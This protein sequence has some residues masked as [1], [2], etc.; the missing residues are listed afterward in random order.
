M[1]DLE[2]LKR[3]YVTKTYVT[4]TWSELLLE[5]ELLLEEESRRQFLEKLSYTSQKNLLRLYNLKRKNSLSNTQLKAEISKSAITQAVLFGSNLNG[6]DGLYQERGFWTRQVAKFIKKSQSWLDLSKIRLTALF[7]QIRSRVFPEIEVNKLAQLKK[8][9]EPASLPLVSKISQPQSP[10]VHWKVLSAGFTVFMIAYLVGPSLY[11]QSLSLYSSLQKQVY[12][13]TDDY[14]QWSAVFVHSSQND[15]NQDPDVDGLTNQ[16][17]FWLKTDPM[18]ADQNENNI[19]DGADVLN[20]THPHNGASADSVNLSKNLISYRLQKIAL[21][22]EKQVDKQEV[23][24]VNSFRPEVNTEFKGSLSIPTL[25]YENVPIAWNVTGEEDDFYDVLL[26]EIIHSKDSALPGYPGKM[27]L[28][29]FNS[30][31]ETGVD[32]IINFN[33]IYKLEPRDEILVQAEALDGSTWQWKYLVVSRNLFVPSDVSQF[34]E[35]E[36][37]ELQLVTL[38]TESGGSKVISFNARYV[39][40]EKLA[41]LNKEGEKVDE[42]VEEVEGEKIE[43][44]ATELETESLTSEDISRILLDGITSLS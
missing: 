16:E 19:L 12:A 15:P 23:L 10:K 44:E 6:V 9:L 3:R 22:K 38:D 27:H 13:E 29:G 21:Q 43:D 14:S 5:Y 1:N 8:R 25:G 31:V 24:G 33:E 7:D 34:V 30:Q 35:D 37:S 11:T 2:L 28:F 40:E 36:L 26:A 39:G 18:I 4:K 41:T 17:E 32:S 42:V 20:N